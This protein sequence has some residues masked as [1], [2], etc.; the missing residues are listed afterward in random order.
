MKKFNW[1]TRQ[2]RSRRLSSPDFNPDTLLPH[3][4]DVLKYS[5]ARKR[6][7]KAAKAARWVEIMK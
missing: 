7:R 5:R 4:G 3:S 2:G 1:T 6:G